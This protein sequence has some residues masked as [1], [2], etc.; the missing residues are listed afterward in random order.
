LHEDRL[1]IHNSQLTSY[2]YI[3]YLCGLVSIGLLYYE[4][5]KFDCPDLNSS[6]PSFI[7]FSLHFFP[8]IVEHKFSK[9]SAQKGKIFLIKP[10]TVNEDYIKKLLQQKFSPQMQ[11]TTPILEPLQEK[12]NLDLTRFFQE[13]ERNIF[14]NLPTNIHFP[15]IHKYLS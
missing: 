10:N 3:P 2:L 5:E 7:C 9:M 6:F 4:Y 1:S 15:C 14:L 11:S 13:I 12:E 8:V